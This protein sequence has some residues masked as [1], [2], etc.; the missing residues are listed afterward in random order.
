MRILLALLLLSASCIVSCT[1]TR[2]IIPLKDGESQISAAFGGPLITYSDM[3]IPVPL[4]SLEYGYGLDANITLFGGAHIT[5]AL[6]GVIQADLGMR[7]GI[8]DPLDWQPGVTLGASL[9]PAIDV[10]EG[11]AKLW[12]ELMAA[13]RWKVGDNNPYLALSTW[14]EL[15]STRG[16]DQKQDVHFMPS[17]SIGDIY[18]STNWDY[19]LEARWIAPGLSNKG[20]VAEYHGIS[21]NGAIGLYFSVGRRFGL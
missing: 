18:Q 20:V 10:W 3:V 19:A 1:P 17:I 5:S 2:H 7:Y 9:N 13:A 15:A 8:M 16:H 11:N 4:I 12:P 14:I 21:N 6:F